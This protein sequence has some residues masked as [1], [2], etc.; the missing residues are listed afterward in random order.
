VIALRTADPSSCQRGRPTET[1]LQI[2]DRSIPTGSNT[3]S[4]VISNLK[5]SVNGFNSISHTRSKWRPACIEVPG[6][7]LVPPT[8]TALMPQPPA[9]MRPTTEGSEL[10][11]TVDSE[12]AQITFMAGATSAQLSSLWPHRYSRRD[13]GRVPTMKNDP[14]QRQHKCSK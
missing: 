6:S 11:S 13:L 1:R 7:L 10:P 8:P 2:S 3:W 4:R 12:N 5:N 14:F 9:Q